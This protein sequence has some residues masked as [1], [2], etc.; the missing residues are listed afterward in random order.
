MEDVAADEAEFAL[1]VERREDLARDDRRL[2]VRRVSFDRVD[3]EVRDRLARL[4]P[5]APVRQVFGATCWQNRDAT[6]RPGG[7]SESSS[8]EEISISMI[9]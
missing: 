4:I 5:G 3:H 9:G 8:V 1:E 2:E 7:A 6:C